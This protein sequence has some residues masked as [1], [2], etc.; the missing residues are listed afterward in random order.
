MAIRIVGKGMKFVMSGKKIGAVI[1]DG[2]G[3]ELSF[4]PSAVVK[5]AEYFSVVAK[6]LGNPSGDN[7]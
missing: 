5:L 2:D 3:L 4:T 6:S 1:V 7:Q